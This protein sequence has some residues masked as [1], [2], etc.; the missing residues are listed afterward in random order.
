MANVIEL[1][2]ENG[3]KE[4]VQSLEGVQ[5]KFLGDN[6]RVTFK[7]PIPARKRCVFN[8]G[9][10]CSIE[11]DSSTRYIN[12]L[13]IE[14][15][16]PNCHVK[17]GK[18]FS[19]YLT[20]IHLA[21]ERDLSVTVGDYCIFAKG[22]TI[23]TSDAHSIINKSTGEIVNEGKSVV[24]GNHV[25]ITTDCYVL[26]GVYLPDWTIVA[27][28]AIVTKSFEETNCIVGGAPAK[29]LKRDVLWDYRDPY[30][31]NNPLS[32]QKLQSEIIEVKEPSN[33]KEEEIYFD[34]I[35]IEAKKDVWNS[36][37]FPPTLKLEPETIYKIEINDSKVIKGDYIFFQLAIKNV[38]ANKPIML[39]N[40]FIGCKFAMTIKTPKQ[41]DNI[42]I[43]L[44]SGE[45][46]SASDKALSVEG[47]RLAKIVPVSE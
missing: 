27:A 37:I 42:Q 25:W 5:I 15:T 47:F 40:I 35:D 16:A 10:N 24:I 21:N 46:G 28:G 13:I 30:L 2:N 34:D 32:G 3:T 8:V 1:I 7:K 6:S 18:N 23:R 12:D 4:V 41:I 19:C 17:F 11:L 36:Y 26:K 33:Y 9:D 29:I 39:K 22:T 38:T 45:A 43:K 20:R 31:M 14:A 44:Y